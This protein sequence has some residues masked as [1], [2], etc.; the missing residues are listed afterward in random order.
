MF[1]SLQEDDD[2]CYYPSRRELSF[3]QNSVEYLGEIF[4]SSNRQFFKN[5]TS[6]EIV[7]Q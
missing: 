5:F 4:Y 1:F 6:H 7:T 3:E 2:P